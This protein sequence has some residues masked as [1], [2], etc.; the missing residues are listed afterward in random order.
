MFVFISTEDHIL[1]PCPPPNPDQS[2]KRAI[3]FTN[4]LNTRDNHDSRKQNDCFLEL[5]PALEI[6]SKNVS[7]WHYVN[8]YKGPLSS[9]PSAEHSLPL[10]GKMDLVLLLVQ[11]L[12][13]MLRELRWRYFTELADRCVIKRR[14]KWPWAIPS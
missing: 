4:I 6:I 8:S 5:S 9:W 14:S 11:P 3:I 7:D 12:E 10:V 13:Q 2:N 1:T